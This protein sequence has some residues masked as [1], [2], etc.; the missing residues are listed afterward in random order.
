M[1]LRLLVVWCEDVRS[2]LGDG[3]GERGKIQ[4]L[5]RGKEMKRAARTTTAS[6]LLEVA[7]FELVYTY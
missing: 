1:V 7:L 4:L 6:C 3:C 2:L 5:L